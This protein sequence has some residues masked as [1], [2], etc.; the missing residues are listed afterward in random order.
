MTGISFKRLSRLW[1][2]MLS[3]LVGV[4]LTTDASADDFSMSKMTANRWHLL[5]RQ[6]PE[7]PLRFRC[8]HPGRKVLQ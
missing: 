6:K 7:N 2:A 3:A 5:H 8:Q 1:P 4:L